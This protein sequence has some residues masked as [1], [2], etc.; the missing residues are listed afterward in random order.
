LAVLAP[1]TAD[2]W[3]EAL[4]QAVRD[5]SAFAAR[6][7]AAQEYLWTKRSVPV[8]AEQQL[9]LLRSVAD[10]KPPSPDL[11]HSDPVAAANPG[12]SL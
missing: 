11:N 3:Y 6:I 12:H 7:A 5:P 4:R 2:E 1:N 10:S 8:M 9:G